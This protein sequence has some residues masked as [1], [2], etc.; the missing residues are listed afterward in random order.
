MS[1]AAEKNALIEIITSEEDSV[2]NRSLDE[3]CEGASLQEL[4]SHCEA[5]ESYWRQTDNLY[6]RVRALFFLFSIHRFQLPQHYG[7]EHRGKIPFTAY[8]NLLERRFSE[9]VDELLDTQKQVGPSDGLS[10]ALANSYYELGF[11]TLADQVRKS[12]RTVRGNQW[13]FRTGHPADHP[14]RFRKELLVKGDDEASYPMLRRR[15]RFEWTSRT[16]VGATSFSWVW[17][18]RQA[19]ESS[20]HR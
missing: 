10:S 9:A 8:Q 3:V 1:I 6:H 13:M 11:Q 4:M 5:L 20:T 7:L 19:P 14:L 2:R 18:F 17:T 16:A 15:P 12:V